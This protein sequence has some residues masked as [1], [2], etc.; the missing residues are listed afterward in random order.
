MKNKDAPFMWISRM[1]QPRFTSRE[2]WIVDSKA[3][4]DS[5]A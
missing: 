1:I 5:G 2:I 3:I 4:D